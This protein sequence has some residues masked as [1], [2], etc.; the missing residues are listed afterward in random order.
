MD[1][2][3]LPGRRDDAFLRPVRRGA[4]PGDGPELRGSRREGG[5]CPDERRRPRRPFGGPAQYE[6]TFDRAVVLYAKSLILLMTLPFMALLPLVFL[7]E[8]RPFM[9]HVVFSVH[10]YTFLLL[11]FCL[12]LL[13]A[14]LSAWLGF[15]GLDT[16][17]VDTVLSVVSFIACSVYIHLAI[18]PVYGSAGARR[19]AQT[20]VLVLSVSAIVI[21]YRFAL[22]FITLYAT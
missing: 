4:G 20:V 12:A 3:R 7:S 11:L 19:I 1:L 15:G 9:T 17:R 13:A 2:S 16:P 18:G 5:P 6:P 21:G 22:F 8:R 10:L 14:K